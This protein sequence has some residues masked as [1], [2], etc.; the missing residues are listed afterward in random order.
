MIQ[1]QFISL[2]VNV[3]TG[4]LPCLTDLSLRAPGAYVYPV[5]FLP[6]PNLSSVK[7]PE[8][9]RLNT[10]TASPS[11]SQASLHPCKA[12]VAML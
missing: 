8:I 6:S 3:C 11:A 9:G 5:K 2:N 12:T 1:L 7:N 4:F 10:N